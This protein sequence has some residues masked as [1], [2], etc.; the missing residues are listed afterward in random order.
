MLNLNPAEGGGGQIDQASIILVT[1]KMDTIKGSLNK[2]KSK[3]FA[4]LGYPL[5]LIAIFL[6]FRKKIMKLNA[7]VVNLAKL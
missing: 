3:L 6:A 2:F 4:L 1:Q 5:M 7:E